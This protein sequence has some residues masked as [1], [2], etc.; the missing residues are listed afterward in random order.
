MIMNNTFKIHQRHY[1]TFA[2][3]DEEVR[4]QNESPCYYSLDNLGVL[5]IEGENAKS[6]L[7]GQLSCDMENINNTFSHRGTYCTVKG[8]VLS[9]MHVFS[10]QQGYLL[11][12]PKDLMEVTSN[13][14]KRVALFSKVTVTLKPTHVFGLT[15]PQK[16]QS[17]FFDIEENRNIELNGSTLTKIKEG[18]FLG[19]SEAKPL[20]DKNYIELGS[21]SWHFFKLS[22]TLPSIYPQTQKQFLPQDLNLIEDKSVCLK[23]GCYIGQEVIARVHFKAK[24]KYKTELFITSKN[25][26]LPGDDL[27]FEQ[28]NIGEIIDYC[29]APRNQY[30]YLARLLKDKKLDFYEHNQCYI[31]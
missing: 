3:L 5:Y 24:E 21:L 22:H 31:L 1:T 9:L 6:F 30:L 12:L 25:L 26:G 10:Y 11:I 23:K 7:Q 8:R 20:V 16:Y 14:L 18:L 19:F 27:C 15:L 28:K 29:P 17:S 4:Q 13:K 2:L